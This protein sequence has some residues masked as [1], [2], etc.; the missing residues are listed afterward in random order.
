MQEWPYVHTLWQIQ[1][2]IISCQVDDGSG[3]TRRNSAPGRVS[4]APH[5]THTSCDGMRGRMHT[6]VLVSSRVHELSIAESAAA[7]SPCCARARIAARACKRLRQRH[8]TTLSTALPRALP[9]TPSHLGVAART[10]PV[11]VGVRVV[12]HTKLRAV[13]GGQGQRHKAVTARWAAADA[14][15]VPG[16]RTGHIHKMF[17][18]TIFVPSGVS[19]GRGA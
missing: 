5:L 3:S 14:L 12:L 13:L 10:Q 17:G 7:V 19:S 18:S 2:S 16:K 4:A 1:K 6:T 8:A 15:F 9:I 11:N